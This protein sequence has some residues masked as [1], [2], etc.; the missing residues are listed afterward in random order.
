MNTD[1]VEKLLRK[2]PPLRTP[3][4]LLRHLQSDIPLPG[5][6]SR[7]LKFKPL[8]LGARVRRWLPA[9]G[10]TLWFLGCL[11]VFG[12]QASRI[13]ALKERDRERQ[14]ANAVASEQAEKAAARSAA[15]V[16]ELEQLKRDLS[17]VQRLRAEVEQLRGEAAELAALRAQNS[18]LRD[19]LK[20]KGPPL[21]KPEEEFFTEAA[22]R[23]ARLKCVNNLKQVGLAARLW[24]NAN[25]TD[26]FP[27]DTT[28][29]AEF[30]GDETK[31]KATLACPADG[32]TAYEILSPGASENEPAVVYVRCRIHNNVGLV[33][34]SV[35]QLGNNR[36]LL[37]KD[38]KW[39]I[40]P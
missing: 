1:L 13:T 22:S 32:T 2:A 3:P 20:R 40:S 8:N 7:P 30:L 12:I 25:K 15:N 29:L 10:F 26:A 28:Q 18:Q 17:N 9:L 36:T 27:S 34:G 23:P 16:A 19:E 21:P 33:D 39:I 5:G 35:Q 14:Q 31:A 6:E 38:G 37:Q 24:A 4:E 11:V